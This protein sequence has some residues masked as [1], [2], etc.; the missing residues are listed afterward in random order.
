MLKSGGT[1]A[2]N[3]G[4]NKGTKIVLIKRGSCVWGAAQMAV[5][6]IATYTILELGEA[7]GTAETASELA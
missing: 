4:N 2:Q 1:S 3:H 6:L 5:S 7:S